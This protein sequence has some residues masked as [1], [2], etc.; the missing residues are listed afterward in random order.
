MLRAF[1]LAGL[2]SV[3]AT[4]GAASSATRNADA[5]DPGLIVYWSE[6]PDWPTIWSI[7]LD[8]SHRRRILHNRQNAKRPSLSPDRK[9]VAFDGTPPGKPPLTDFDIQVVRLDGTSLRTVTKSPKW[10]VDAQWSPDGTRLSFTRLPPSPVDA[11]DA[12]IWTVRR[13]GSDPRLVV[14]GSTARWSPDG[15]KLAYTAPT[16][17]SEGDLFVVNVDGSE[18]RLVLSTPELEEPAGWSPD[19]TRI[20][21]TRT[22]VGRDSEVFVMNVDGTGAQK[23][24]HGHAGSWSPDGSKILYT[25]FS[26]LSVMRADGSHKRRISRVPARDPSWR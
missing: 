4:V 23:L 16:D 24:A 1:V 19:G 13:D 6:F 22:P 5:P 11:R 21:Y 8:G 17:G 14:A 18:P 9:L 25:S 2:A 7:R 20:L 3:L 12:H 15:T 26:Q 10:D